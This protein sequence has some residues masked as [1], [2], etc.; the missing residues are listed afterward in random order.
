MPTARM[1]QRRTANYQ[2]RADVSTEAK[3]QGRQ[4]LIQLGRVERAYV[5]KLV[6]LELVRIAHVCVGSPQ[7]QPICCMK[8]FWYCRVNNK[9]Q[10]RQAQGS[11]MC[12]CVRVYEMGAS[13]DLVL[14]G[15]STK[16]E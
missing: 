15:L 7:L 16:A 4:G 6:F 1:T 2:Q 11:N 3:R 14:R 13:S 5:D 9:D 10:Q 12:A 8:Q